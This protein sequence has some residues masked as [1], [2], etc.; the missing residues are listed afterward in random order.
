MDFEQDVASTFGNN[1]AT[2]K[3]PNPKQTEA[4][5]PQTE[6]KPTPTS[7][8]AQATQTSEKTEEIVADIDVAMEED[9]TG[10]RV[11]KSGEQTK[12]NPLFFFW[13]D[14]C[15]YEFRNVN[16]VNISW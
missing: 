8:E 5:T 2:S 13:G 15:G 10:D 12:V 4:H 9:T 3:T 6:P 11:D 7:E 1:E 16:V 14:L